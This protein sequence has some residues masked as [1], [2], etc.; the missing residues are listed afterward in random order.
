M[1]SN[2]EIGSVPVL[3]SVSC[4]ATGVCVAVGYYTD[5]GGNR[6][7]LLETLSS[8][9]WT[10]T[11]AP[12]PTEADGSPDAELS[13]VSCADGNNCA[14]VG[15][16]RDSKGFWPG[17]LETWS[18]G[19][20]TATEA[21]LPAGDDYSDTPFL[22]SVSC[23]AVGSCVAVGSTP[24]SDN[25][26][27][28]LETLSGGTWTAT[29]APLPAEMTDGELYSV[30]CSAAGSCAAA[31]DS[32]HLNHHEVLLETLSAGTWTVT[33]GLLP[34][35]AGQTQPT[36]VSCLVPGYC[37]AVADYGYGAPNTDYGWII[38]TL[39][40]GTWRATESPLPQGNGLHRTWLSSV[41]CA[42]IGVCVAVGW[43]TASDTFYG[44]TETLSG[45]TW[46]AVQPPLPPGGE[47]IWLTS[48]SCA[49][50][51]S[52]VA[53]GH[54]NDVNSGEQGLIES[55]SDAAWTG[56]QAPLPS[57]AESDGGPVLNSVSCGA[58]GS[59]AAVGYYNND[60]NDV[61][62]GSS[63]GLLEAL[64]NGT[65]PGGTVPRSCPVYV[66]VGARGSGEAW[67]T[68]T[69]G[70][71]Q[72]NDD[73]FSYLDRH[74][75]SMANTPQ[76]V[77]YPAVSL[78][79][80]WDVALAA[81]TIGGATLGVSTGLLGAYKES[82]HDG[83]QWLTG[84]IETYRY[85]A[86]CPDT[87]FILSG[88]SQGAQVVA[89]TVTSLPAAYRHLVAGVVLFGDPQFNGQDTAVDSSTFDTDRYGALSSTDGTRE[90]PAWL[91]GQVF[92]FCHQNDPI[93]QLDLRHG[94]GFT[95]S[96][97]EVMIR[98]LVTGNPLKEH[99]NYDNSVDVSHAASD[100]ANS[101]LY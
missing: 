43:Y 56:T 8:G 44:L 97:T 55:L 75:K 45:G 1:P 84:Y 62:S 46:R 87:K 51:S 20:W 28:L 30:S 52:C 21:P 6:R 19:T 38:E 34:A 53:V 3:A 64:S 42:A 58:V 68:K 16:Y 71:G 93:C 22:A 2:A 85:T 17:L 27:G 18:G 89:D 96:P 15:R 86:G 91:S 47:T 88:Y 82:V 32:Y 66:F 80:G 26:A 100:V 59:C 73:V 49:D 79:D 25:N 94:A 13:S 77:E 70:M 50:G 81:I 98:N 7:G 10:A 99:S 74:L 40:D 78:S 4:A 63:K 72:L 41:S 29:E 39:S 23:G 36:S 83:I 12:L 37:V 65:S 24:I 31:G 76:G 90:F 48:V 92:S 11:E 61:P 14:A 60:S 69:F 67:N 95:I 101:I 54:Y 57:N 5:T 35:G 9:T 33:G